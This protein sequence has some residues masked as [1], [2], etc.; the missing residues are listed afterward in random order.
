MGHPQVIS[1]HSKWNP[2]WHEYLRGSNQRMVFIVRDLRDIAVSNHYY[3][4]K[5]RSH[6]L[7]RYFQNLETDQARL[8]ASIGGITSDEL[9]GALP[10]LSLRKHAEGYRGWISE[11]FCH[12]VRF[13][14]LIGAGGGGND[15]KQSKAIGGLFAYVGIQLQPREIQEIASSA[16]SHKSRTFRKGLAGDWKNHLNGDSKQ[17]V[18]EQLGDLLIEFGYETDLSW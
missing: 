7:H 17:F 10:S 2:E 6:R 13:E 16:I 15:E 5:D 18:K 9:S 3:I 8:M 4:M 14:D 12:V 11:T 1:L